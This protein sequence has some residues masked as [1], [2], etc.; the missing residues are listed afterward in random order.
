MNINLSSSSIVGTMITSFLVVLACSLLVKAHPFPPQFH[1]NP[2]QNWES[3]ILSR[4]GPSTTTTPRPTRWTTTTLRSF[5]IA[6]LTG[7]GKATFQE[8]KIATSRSKKP[9]RLVTADSS[10]NAAPETMPP[11][12]GSA[13]WSALLVKLW[14]HYFLK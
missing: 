12:Y 7:T 5:G 9:Y 8:A 1:Q 10:S 13:L 4:N 2:A 14:C 11:S 6:P 3:V